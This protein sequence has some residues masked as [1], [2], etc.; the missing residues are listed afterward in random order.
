MKAE[1]FRNQVVD[2]SALQLRLSSPNRT[3]LTSLAQIVDVWERDWILF[4]PTVIEDFRQR[5]SGVISTAA[6]RD[7]SLDTEMASLTP[8]T[9]NPSAP[10]FA[11]S[12][13]PAEPVP[14]SSAPSPAPAPAP[15]A[16][17]AKR[18]FKIGGFK[19]T[20]QPSALDV[21]LPDEAEDV[22]GAPVEDVDGEVVDV[23]GE[24]VDVDGEAL[25]VDGEVML[26]DVDGAPL[27]EGKGETKTVVLDDDEAM[28][29]A[30]SDDD[31]F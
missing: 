25:D 24:A 2:V 13:A 30:Q 18:G 4:E 10:S 7:E 22:D 31:I 19:T 1:Q 16:P 15:E 14:V 23:D 21:E 9:L 5:L 17:P 20:F 12:F 11:S 26:D 29:L 28:D 27:I 3:D 8:S 6:E